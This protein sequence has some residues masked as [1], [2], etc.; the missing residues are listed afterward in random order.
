MYALV[1]ICASCLAVELANARWAHPNGSETRRSVLGWASA[2][3]SYAG[4]S[5]F[6]ATTT[7]PLQLVSVAFLMWLIAAHRGRDTTTG[8]PWRDLGALWMA[9]ALGSLACSKETPL[10]TLLLVGIV[11]SAV[12][13][14]LSAM[15]KIAGTER[16]AALDRSETEAAP[17]DS[18]QS[19]AQHDST[20]HDLSNAMTASLFM[21]RDLSRALDKGTE[22]SLTRARSLSQELVREL[23]QIGEHI[24]SS[25]QSV[26][27]QPIVGAAINLVEPLGRCVELVARLY[28]DVRCRVDCAASASDAMVSMI[29]GEATLKRIVEN[30]VINAC[31][32]ERGSAPKE[33]VCRVAIVDD[34][35]I[36]TVEDNGVGFP[37]IVLDSYPSPKVSTKA[38]GS[39]IGLYSCH[40]LV[41]RDGGILTISNLDSGGAR[42]TVGWPLVVVSPQPTSA[43]KDSDVMI[44]GTRTRPD[45]IDREHTAENKP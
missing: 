21:V 7:R 39:G 45:N 11:G 10:V 42:V 43:V 9:L 36:L 3:L 24:R 26:R 12:T 1:T 13:L 44:S 29:G 16:S 6:I 30:L 2:L 32:A 33:I 19:W 28:P 27:L 34:T 22:P 14:T 31:Q 18:E 41:K 25:R 40:Q 4:A 17:R 15:G 38:Q 23:S 37:R 5:I 35:V 20:L 8:L